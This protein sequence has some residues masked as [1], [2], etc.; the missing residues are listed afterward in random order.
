MI[1]C[2]L[3]VTT[4]VGIGKRGSHQALAIRLSAQDS[5]SRVRHLGTYFEENVAGRVAGEFRLGTG[6][7]KSRE[8]LSTHELFMLVAC[9]THAPSV[10]SLNGWIAGHF[11]A[12]IAQTADENARGAIPAA[13][14]LGRIRIYRWLIKMEHPSRS[15]TQA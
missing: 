2:D 6:V 3:Y 12:E 14:E 15:S 13:P 5:S 9:V 7:M 4:S 1:A 8:E 11:S 10:L